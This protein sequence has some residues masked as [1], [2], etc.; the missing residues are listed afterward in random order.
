M[1]D[2]RT[3]LSRRRLVQGAAWSAPVIVVATATPGHAAAVSG[4]PTV[5]VT[6]V[7]GVRRTAAGQTNRIDAAVTF[8]NNGPGDATALSALIEWVNVGP[9]GVNNL[10]TD[11]SAPWTNTPPVVGQSLGVQ[12]T[13]TRAGGLAAGQTDTLLFTF[14]SESGS[15]TLTVD[16]PETSP[17]GANTGRAGTWGAASPAPPAIVVSALN[18]VR[19]DTPGETDLIDVTATFTNN[20]GAAS[21]LNAQLEWVV[22]GMGQASNTISNVSS[23]WV[24][25]ASG[26]GAGFQRTF[27]RTG[28]L[29]A[30]A[31]DTLTFTFQSNGGRGTIS[32][33]PTTTPTGTHS[34]TGG[35]WGDTDAIDMDVT[36][37]SSPID[38]GRI[39][40]NL[41]NN[42]PLPIPRH[43][44]EVVITP[45]S[46][47]VGLTSSGGVGNFY[48]AS[49]TSRA[50]NTTPMTIRFTYPLPLDAGA[51]NSFNFVIDQTGSGTVTARVVDP[52]SPN[53]ASANGTYL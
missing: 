12:S 20:G 49:P 32:A 52:A 45:T 7:T 13:F 15:G 19:R 34:G 37:I 4:A 16:N 10:V 48:T 51:S 43:V 2:D 28:G 26:F 36:G 50:A 11:V 18:G 25:G 40:I 38:N 53:N 14:G 47:T 6:T 35:T 39:F 5:V 33:A 22:T 31:S 46:G 42:G 29:G 23:N 9:G 21:A 24:A 3:G 8:T 17:T 1:T 44:V 41:K 27:S 30:G